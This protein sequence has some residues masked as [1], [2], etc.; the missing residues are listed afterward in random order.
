MR[1]RAGLAAA[2][3]IL[4]GSG[5]QATAS[6]R[7]RERPLGDIA[8]IGVPSTLETD[9][10]V[11]QADELMHRLAYQFSSQYFWASMGGVAR[12]RQL[13]VVSVL[14]SDAGASDDGI[15]PWP[16]SYESRAPLR[17]M[18]LGGG[19][20]QITDTIYALGADR[21]AAV[22]YLYTDRER[23]LQI[24]WHVVKS[25]HEPS[26]ASGLIGRMAASFRLLRDPAPLLAER[27]ARPNREASDRQMRIA[28][29]KAMLER[30]GYG[31]PA[32]RRPIW[33]QGAFLEWMDEP[34]SRYQL[35]APLG[36][37]RAAAEGSVAQRPRPLH[38]GPDAEGLGWREHRDGAWQFANR[39]N[40]YLPFAGI[41]AALAV[42]QRD[43]AYLYFYWAATVRVEEEVD[44]R[45]LH[46]LAWYFAA[47]PKVKDRWTRG[48]L[49]GP[50]QP[51][52]DEWPP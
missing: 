7:L 47:L 43:S 33:R 28:A 3:V 51:E 52:V 34:E 5:P 23:R 40:D 10:Y 12:Y 21:V 49:V 15:R 1:R 37:M 36:R 14:A 27:R 44:P 20:L 16:I 45:R 6:S 46:S 2:F 30:E 24:L 29:V 17:A 38:G 39:D 32:P 26:D 35:L 42:R 31:V 48:G 25:Q 50:G 13:M 8:V 9:R 19:Q 41:A 11:G 18:S 4:A 22:E